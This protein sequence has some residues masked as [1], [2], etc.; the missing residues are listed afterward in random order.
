MKQVRGQ[1]ILE[2][3]GL[4]TTSPPAARGSPQTELAPW[5]DDP[6]AANCER[7]FCV[8]PMADP[9]LTSSTGKMP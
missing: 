6:P 5:P 4:P 1:A 9:L 2:H 7:S 8:R 3:L